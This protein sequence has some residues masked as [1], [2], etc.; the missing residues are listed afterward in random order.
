MS[1]LPWQLSSRCNKCSR[2]SCSKRRLCSLVRLHQL[3]HN[4]PGQSR[5][6]KLRRQIGG[7]RAL[8]HARDVARRATFEVAFATTW[9]V[10][11]GC[12][13][14]KFFCFARYSLL[15]RERIPLLDRD[16]L[17]SVIAAHGQSIQ[18]LAFTT[19]NPKEP[20]DK[21]LRWGAPDWNQGNVNTKRVQKAKKNKGK[22]RGAWIGEV[23]RP[24][25]MAVEKVTPN[26]LK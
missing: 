18:E 14:Q 1:G 19:H 5:L 15:N 24:T 8:A 9:N 10:S 16:M 13:V 12:V 17:N 25:T 23:K 2:C 21:L 20:G 22:K 3:H 6:Q 7:T 26:N 11:L 4:K